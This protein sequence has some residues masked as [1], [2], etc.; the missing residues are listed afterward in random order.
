MARTT[1]LEA[2]RTRERLV[3]TAAR[4][5]RAQGVAGTSIPSL[6]EHVG[7][8]HG[9]FYAHFDSKEALVAE[10][11]V[12]GLRETVDRLLRRAEAAPLGQGLQAVI[13]RYLSP[14]HR[15]D[16]AN[17]CVL[18]ALASEV[19]R[20]PAPV[21][22]AFTN[23]FKEYIERL[24]PLLAA[25]EPDA[26]AK[27]RANDELILASGLAG[28]VLLAR[29]VDDPELSDRILTSCRDFYLAAFAPAT[30]RSAE[31]PVDVS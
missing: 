26:D 25:H 20:E 3:E 2:A 22:H 29:A 18:P 10:A 17:G 1:K 9:A 7:L 27:R 19:R 31:A 30:E 24:T 16:P 11:Y 6:M 21:R 4:D 14:E 12:R 28:A 8:T 15:D 5:F 13:E 23:A